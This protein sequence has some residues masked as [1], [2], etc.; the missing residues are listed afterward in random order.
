[1]C[2]NCPPSRLWPLEEEVQSGNIVVRRSFCSPLDLKN[3]YLLHQP[4]TWPHQLGGPGRRRSQKFSF[5]KFWFSWPMGGEA[6][7]IDQPLIPQWQWPYYWFWGGPVGQWTSSSTWRRLR[8]AKPGISHPNP[9][10]T[11]RFWEARREMGQQDES[12]Q[13]HKKM[14]AKE[15]AAR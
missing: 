9:R 11:A 5:P 2:P 1:M 3:N 12:H 15:R 8:P 14:T 13:L 10:G 7:S 6:K 4:G